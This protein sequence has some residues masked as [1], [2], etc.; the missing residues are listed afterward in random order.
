MHSDIIDTKIINGNYY[1]KK[2]QETL[3]KEVEAL[4]LKNIIPKL[5]INIILN[6]II[7]FR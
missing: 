5:I 3:K 1:A 4:A 7:K 2:L 6:L